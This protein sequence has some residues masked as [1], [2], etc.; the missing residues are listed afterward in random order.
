MKHGFTARPG[1]KASVFKSVVTFLNRP[2]EARQVG[3]NVK[4]LLIVFFDIHGLENYE[5]VLD[6]QTE[7][8]HYY[9]Q[10]LLRL[11]EKVRRQWSQLF[12]SGRWLLLHNSAPAHTAL[13]IQEFLAEKE[14]PVVPHP[15]YSLDLAHC[16]FFLFHRIKIM[17]KGEDFMTLTP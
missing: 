15:P 16:D 6:G 12:Q 2:K 5:F 11:R 7:N 17:L 13:S 9:K 3:L 8:Q 1:N 14:V 10:A 4:K